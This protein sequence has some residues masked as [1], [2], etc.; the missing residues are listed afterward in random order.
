[1]PT[2]AS[3]LR[4]LLASTSPWRRQICAQVGLDLEAVDPRVDEAS[5]V[6]SDPV[7][8]ALTRA[9]AKADSLAAPD[10]VVIGADQVCH[11]DGR[12]YGK[13]ESDE[14]HRDQLR[15]LRGRTH[16]L[17]D[18]VSVVAPHARFDEVVSVR[19][20]LRADLSDEE[21][22]A[23]V[24][25]GDARGCAGGYRAEGRGA[26][27]IERIDGDAFAVMG[28]PIYSVLTTLRALGWR[29]LAPRHTSGGLLPGSSE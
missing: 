28:L 8:L 12:M 13:P 27:L 5:I 6:H 11:L 7:V 2:N 22:E 23:Y 24:A 10:C 1:M 14:E 17:S 29:C 4:L 16:T 18:G 19:V 15:A 3:G 25:S 9:R 26:W 20:T 21:I